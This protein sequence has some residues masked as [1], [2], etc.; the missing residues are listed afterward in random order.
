MFPPFIPIIPPVG[1][2]SLPLLQVK[3]RQV[4]LLAQGYTTYKQWHR[5]LRTHVPDGFKRWCWR[6]LLR[7]AWKVKI[8]PVNPKGNQ[9]W[10]FIGRPDAEAPI[11]WSP[12]VNSQL[13]GKKPWCWKR[14]RTEG[15]EGIRG[16]DGWMASPTQWTWTWANSGSLWGTGKPDLLQSMGLQKSQ[17]QLGD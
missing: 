8:K 7:I 16:W 14:L 11:F 4:K 10:I 17:T 3:W 6:R 5:W 12:D 13:I 9:P 2:I 1:K 15:E